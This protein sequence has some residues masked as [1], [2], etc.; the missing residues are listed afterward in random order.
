MNLPP[1]Y[2]ILV[3][4]FKH[5]DKLVLGQS[6]GDDNRLLAAEGLFFKVSDLAWSAAKLAEDDAWYHQENIR[7]NPVSALNVIAR[8]SY[9]TSIVFHHVFIG[10]KNE[11]DAEMRYW[12]WKKRSLEAKKSLT[13]HVYPQKPQPDL[14]KDLNIADEKI[15]K[16]EAFKQLP[17][18][19]Q[20]YLL[21]NAGKNS[22]NNMGKEAGVGKM[23]RKTIYEYL[24][25]YAHSGYG[26]IVEIQ[27]AGRHPLVQGQMQIAIKIIMISMG[28]MISNYLELWGHDLSLL[29]DDEKEA[30]SFWKSQA[31]L[32]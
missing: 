16:N 3:N 1:E 13:S 4:A 24:C 7:I 10:Y 14:D 26:S 31:S 21:R 17:R 19:K 29:E 9:E 25:G 2:P 27:F 22:W 15:K 28:L 32:D 20:K 5:T 11:T 8:A 18:K 12:L 30:V 23:L 6:A